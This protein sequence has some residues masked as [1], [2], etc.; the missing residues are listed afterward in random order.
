MTRQ[1]EIYCGLDTNGH[2]ITDELGRFLAVATDYP[3]SPGHQHACAR[4][5]ALDLADKH[6]PHGHSISEWQGRWTGPTGRPV[7]EPTMVI[8]WIASAEQVANGEA[9]KKVSRFAGAYK[10]QAFQ[11]SVL[12]TTT[13]LDAVLI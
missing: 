13:E 10:D 6:F 2:A 4:K 11:E 1:Y 3:N 5:L 8:R 9:H 12:I 7:S